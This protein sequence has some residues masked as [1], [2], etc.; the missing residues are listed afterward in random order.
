MKTIVENIGQCRIYLLSLVLVFLLISPSLALP[1]DILTNAQKVNKFNYFNCR[2]YSIGLNQIYNQL[3]YKTRVV[4]GYWI[5]DPPIGKFS[6]FHY[7]C[8]VEVTY[9]G[10]IYWIEPQ[11]GI[12]VKDVEQTT[13]TR[14]IEYSKVMC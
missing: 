13:K 10:K 2:S 3:G 5:Y 1:R 12:L 11:L 14:Y 6:T 4:S 9:K 7:H 8:W